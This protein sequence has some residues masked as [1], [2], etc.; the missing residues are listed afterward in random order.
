MWPRWEKNKTN[1][2]DSGFGWL[3]KIWST[4]FIPFFSFTFLIS[5]CSYVQ[6]WIYIATKS[7]YVSFN[8]KTKI[9]NIESFRST[10]CSVL[11]I[12]LT[13]FYPVIAE[14]NQEM[15]RLFRKCKSDMQTIYGISK[16]NFFLLTN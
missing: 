16:Y 9:K 14:F 6:C 10:F 11:L 13:P 1:K 15:V 3:K 8:K 12:A 4:E 7:I 2:I 5:D